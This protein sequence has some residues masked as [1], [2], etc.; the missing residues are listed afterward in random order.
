MEPDGFYTWSRG[1]DISSDG[2][3]FTGMHDLIIENVSLILHFSIPDALTQDE[4][5]VLL[6]NHGSDKLVTSFANTLQGVNRLENPL[7]ID[8]DQYVDWGW[9]ELEET[10]FTV[11]YVSDNSGLDD[12]EVRVD[13]VGMRVRYHQP[14]YSFEN[15]KAEHTTIIK[16]S[17]IL[18]FDCICEKC[19]TLL[20]LPILTF[21]SI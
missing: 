17:P 2:Y 12:S 13:A 14:W 4:V 11:D 5:N 10:Q 19:Q 6:Q 20:F 1:P 21:S 9:D 7:V 18:E 15:S 16:N 8:L 3:S